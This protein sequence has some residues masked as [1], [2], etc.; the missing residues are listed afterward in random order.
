MKEIQGK[1]ILVWVS[2]RFV[3]ARVQDNGSQLYHKIFPNLVNSSWLWW[4]MRGILADQ[5][6]F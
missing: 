1:S 4:I 2:P 5:K 3:L 6:Y